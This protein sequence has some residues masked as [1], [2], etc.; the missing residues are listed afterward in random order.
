RQKPLTWYKPTSTTD[1][2]GEQSPKPSNISGSQS[3]Q[4]KTALE[5]FSPTI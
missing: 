2:Q 1:Y 5:S 3:I 4:L